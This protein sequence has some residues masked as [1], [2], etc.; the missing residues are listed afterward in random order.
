ML[1]INAHEGAKIYGIDWSRKYRNEIVTCS[2]DNT[3]KFWDVTCLA[4]QPDGVD[5]LPECSMPISPDPLVLPL[6]SFER[7]LQTY[8][9]PSFGGN[10]DSA[11]HPRAVIHTKHP[12]WRARHLPFG[13]GVLGLPQRGDTTLEMW[14]P[15]RPD[16]PIWTAEGHTDVVKEYVWRSK[17]GADLECGERIRPLDRAV[18]AP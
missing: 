16:D 12:M 10:G 9:C 14:V 2:L 8:A 7:T 4:P 1:T 3:I 11:Q 17:G 18:Y 6:P 15:D 5:Y 13:H